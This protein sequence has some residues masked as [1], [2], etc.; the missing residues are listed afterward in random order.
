[1]AVIAI[2]YLEP[3]N[4]AVLFELRKPQPDGRVI[5]KLMQR[6][7]YTAGITGVD[8]GRD[9][10]HHDEARLMAV[11]PRGESLRRPQAAAGDGDRRRVD[12]RGRR[13]HDLHRGIPP[14]AR[15][16]WRRDRLLVV[17]AG[18]QLVERV[19]AVAHQGLRLGA[20][21]QVGR[22]SLLAYA[23]IAGM[24]EYAFVYDD[25]RGTQLVILTSMLALFMLKCRC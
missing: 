13:R 7:V 21:Q 15:A 10:D 5:E 24:I 18:L 23:I 19:P 4:V 14:E 20:L 17:A 25:T 22:W 3:A 12:G 16:D 9:A 11:A 6:F 2:A 1:M 8:A